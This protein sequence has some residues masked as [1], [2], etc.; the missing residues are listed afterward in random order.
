MTTSQENSQLIE[1]KS[2]D[3]VKPEERQGKVKSLFTLWFCTNIAPLAVS[4]GAVATETYHLNMVSAISAIIFGH[5]F[6]GI[7]LALT[8]AQGPQVGIPQ[9]LQSRAQFGRYGSLLLIFFSSVIYLGFFISNITLSGRIINNMVPDV[10]LHAATLIGAIAATLIGV[11]G[12]RFIHK[13]NYIG[14]WVM[15]TALLIGIGIMLFHDLPAGFFTR[16]G[17]S[18]AGWFGTFCIGAVWQISFSPY[19]SDY[20]R[21]LPAKIGV[22]KPFIYTYLGTCGG[23][24]LAFLF[25]MLAVSLVPAGTDTMVASREATGVFGPVLIILFLINIICHNSMNLYGGT[26]SIISSVQTF[27]P[28]WKPALK[29]RVFTSL[30]ILVVCSGVALVAAGDFVSLFLNLIFA[31][32]SVLIPWSMIN[33][34]DFYLIKRMKYDIRSIFSADGGIYGR[35]N[36]TALA[37]YFLGIV[38]QIPFVSNAFFSGPY[39]NIIPGVDISWVISMVVTGIAYP[40]L[41]RRRAQIG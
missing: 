12:Y 10:P 23:T 2:I 25:G 35:A 9:M 27:F 32:I 6:G 16:G 28:S 13:L 33:L 39:A 15:G 26:L 38:V 14:A 11:V 24:I 22:F 21:Y 5:L 7:F 4:T 3:Y 37:V 30:V 19:T 41:S 1:D 40:L 20:S 18:F 34:I 29:V 8:S 36:V 31:L 17:F